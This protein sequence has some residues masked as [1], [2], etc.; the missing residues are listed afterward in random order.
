VVPGNYT[1]NA[2]NSG[3]F[4]FSAWQASNATISN[5]ISPNAIISLT[6]NSVLTAIFNSAVN[7][8]STTTSTSTSISTVT[9]SIPYKFK[10]IIEA[11]NFSNAIIPQ[12]SLPNNLTTY[13]NGTKNVYATNVLILYGNSV[14]GITSPPVNINLFSNFSNNKIISYADQA[15]NSVKVPILYSPNAPLEEISVITNLNTGPIST[16][17]ILSNNITGYVK[18]NKPFYKLIQIN[19]TLSDANVLSAV[20]NFSVNETWINEQNISPSQVTLYKLDSNNSWIPLPTFIV[21]SN[22]ST[23]FYSAV[24]NSLSTYI[25]SYSKGGVYGDVSPE[26]VTLSSGYKLYI[27]AAGANYTFA[28]SAPAFSWTADILAPPGANALGNAN[29]SV[30]HQTSNVCS[31]YT[32]GATHHGLAVAGI[33]LNQKRYVLFTKASGSSTSTSLSYT[34][35]TS[36]SF[37]VLAGAAGYYNF[38][39]ITLP[40]GCSM[41]VRKDNIDKHETAFIAACQNAASG[42]HTLSASLKFKG[43]AALAAY[44]FPPYNA[45]LNDNP[46]T[47][48]ITTNGNTYASGSVMHVI[49]TN[50]ITANPP[51]TGNWI[52]NSWSVSNSLNFSIA[53]TL[54]S[55]TSLTVMGSGTVTA[56]WNGI[57]KFF[58]TGLPNGAKWNVT[59]DS[60]T[61]TGITPNSISFVTPAG[62]YSFSIVPAVYSNNC[63]A[64]TPNV[65]S[66]TLAAGSTQSIS[67]SINKPTLQDGVTM[68][69]GIIGYVPIKLVNSQNTAI[70]APFQQMVSI[71]S[72]VFKPLLSKNLQNVEFFYANGTIIPSWLESGNSNASNYTIYWLKLS[73]GIPANTNLTVYMGFASHNI[74]YMGCT[75]VGEAPEISPTYGQYDKGNTIF[76]YYTNFAGS[77][78]PSGWTMGGSYSVNNG[79]SISTGSGVFDYYNVPFNAPYAVDTYESGNSL[80][81]GE[82]T[83][84]MSSTT[85]IISYVEI[86]L[87]SSLGWALQTSSGSLLNGT[88][89]TNTYY[90][91][92]LEGGSTV[93]AYEN[94]TY[95]ASEN[96]VAMQQ[97][98]GYFTGSTSGDLYSIKWIRV[99][100]YPPNGVMPYEIIGNAF[101]PYLK[102]QSN[103]VNY[104]TSDNVLTES[105]PIIDLLNLF[106][107][108]NV[109]STNTMLINYNI[110]S[111]EPAGTYNITSIDTNSTIFGVS[112][113]NTLRIL[114]PAYFYNGILWNNVSKLDWK[115]I[116]IANPNSGPG[117]STDPNYQSWIDNVTK[118]GGIV[119]GYVYTDYGLRPLSAVESNISEWYTLYPAISGIFLDEYNSSISINSI[120]YGDLYSYIKTNHPSN[121][122]VIAN[123]GVI[124]PAQAMQKV[125]GDANIFNIFEGSYQSFNGFALPTYLKQYG[126]KKFSVIVTNVSQANLQNAETIANESKL[127]CAYFTDNNSA[128]PYATLPRYF[129][130]FTNNTSN[131]LHTT[132]ILKIISNTCTISLSTNSINFGNLNPGVSI[133]TNNGITDTNTGNVNAYMLVYGG[134]WIAGSTHFGVS[135]T[136]WSMT[137]NTQFSSANMLSATAA[138]TAILVPAT[139]SNSIYFGLDIPGGTPT[140]AYTETITIENSC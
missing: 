38:T 95:I 7:I 98:I 103:P 79:L 122:I 33:G 74:N 139:S 19:S 30:G 14:V 105:N 70:P 53:N 73:N 65:I 94:Y 34:V 137:S 59:Y 81:N 2:V 101:P 62:S 118:N 8:T 29:A 11:I 120:Y 119:P 123:P 124:M 41:Q 76:S 3:N 96:S 130:A 21:G 109:V 46:T 117:T 104:G 71:D 28:T 4:V 22:S 132:Q 97:Y 37:V 44:V 100:A 72:N 134:N 12:K 10:N 67:F 121:S 78:L 115:G 110:S 15:L 86:F 77:S 56:T 126:S 136:T 49:G 6:G 90:V 57:T 39:T 5:S 106:I 36:N 32:T 93:S 113:N 66:G 102:L 138:N 54:A 13:F 9:T 87:D 55:S 129:S 27:C 35:T 88:G 116:V 133:A 99:R 47:A 40:S 80:A 127:E 107:N 17:V 45:I 24:S 89:S 82:V 18:F 58:E 68:P 42:G 26:S 92:T 1:I 140:G 43:S 51:N 111:N 69:S 23:Y 112:K 128:N 50:A 85:S 131:T 75:Y 125:A 84:L 83:D 114:V 91:H 63:S 31:A 60:T 61:E 16:N 64:Y 25:V 108:G 52:F 20:Y 135:N 48:T